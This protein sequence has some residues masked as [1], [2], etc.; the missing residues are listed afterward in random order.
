MMWI[1]ATEMTT[2]YQ[3]TKDNCYG[4]LNI[5]NHGKMTFNIS[6]ALISETIH[7]NHIRDSILVIPSCVLITTNPA[8]WIKAQLFDII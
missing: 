3:N 6:F 8:I 5:C 2:E 7:V 1:V 4:K